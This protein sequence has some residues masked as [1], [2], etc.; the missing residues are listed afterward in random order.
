MVAATRQNGGSSATAGGGVAAPPPD[1]M[2]FATSPASAAVIAV[3]GSFSELS[4]AHALGGAGSCATS[5]TASDTAA[6]A[7]IRSFMACRIREEMIW[8]R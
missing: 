6:S 3:C 7:P 4:A 2:S 8:R 5:A 1:G